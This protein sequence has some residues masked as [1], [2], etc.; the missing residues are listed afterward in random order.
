MN[1]LSLPVGKQRDITSERIDIQKG[2]TCKI[3]I[4]VV[5]FMNMNRW[6]W[7]PLATSSDIYLMASS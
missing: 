6:K 2:L 7:M 3:K 5:T 1:A 4:I